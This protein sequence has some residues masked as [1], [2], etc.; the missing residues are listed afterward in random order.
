MVEDNAPAAVDVLASIEKLK[1]EGVRFV[2]MLYS[3]LHGIARGKV[4]PLSAFEDICRH[5]SPFVGAIMTVDLRHNVVA[6]FESGFEDIVAKPDLAT[7][8]V[9]P[10][11]PHIAWCLCDLQ[12]LGAHES[13]PY[14]VDPR[15]A[16]KRA[17]AAYAEIGLTPVMGPEL[18]FY[19]LQQDAT[20]RC[21][22]RRYQDKDSPVYTTGYMAD[23]MGIL[24]TLLE[25]CVALGLGAFAANQE[26]GRGQ[27]EIN[28]GHS[29]AQDSADRAFLFKTLVKDLAAKQGLLATFMG[30]PWNDD[31]GSGFHLHISLEDGSGS[32][33][34]NDASGDDGLSPIAR[35][36]VAGV[37]EHAP[38]LMGFLNPTVNA[39]RRIHPEALVPTRVNWGHDNRFTYIRIPRE[40]GKAT[41]IEVRVA[42][43]A[44]NPY[45]AY[46]A[47]LFAGL[48]G[49]K[50]ALEP[51][52]PLSGLIYEL[53][54][55]QQGAELPSNL[56]DALRAMD[57]DWILK[58][59]MG[60][61]L[62]Q[63]FL[64]IK[65]YELNR[66]RTWVSDWE[67][68]EYAYRL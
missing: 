66:Y 57:E 5:G 1:N 58:D 64:T 21:G 4:I 45:L 35:H 24:E 52:A 22:Y 19:L 67:F 11:E 44:A 43:G 63:T 54:E 31:E 17:M 49:V 18:E 51:V 15:G 48:D 28:L 50:R 41:R 16:L 30:K 62:V 55:E 68:D 59:G 25:N 40:R 26:Y 38:A 53:P 60:E 27:F 34:L 20:V 7:A 14:L 9:L 39:Y 42:D 6:G 56:T 61:A 8:V 29:P 23:P 10:W 47:V 46:A 12:T 37:L 36:F 32:N 2:R 3:D 13:E 33:Q 65:N